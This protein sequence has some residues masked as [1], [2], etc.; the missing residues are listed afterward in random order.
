MQHEYLKPVE[1]CSEELEQA[2][3]NFRDNV[4]ESYTTHS[5]RWSIWSLV[6]DYLDEGIQ[7]CLQ[8][9]G[10]GGFFEGD[11]FSEF[12]KR[13]GKTETD[14]H[15][16]QRYKYFSK[17]VS[18]KDIDQLRYIAFFCYR[19]EP[20]H[21]SNYYRNKVK[22]S[23]LKEYDGADYC[24]LCWRLTRRN[25]RDR[26][27]DI[28]SSRFC[29]IHNPKDHNSL[30]RADHNQKENFRKN[31]RR[32]ERTGYYFNLHAHEQIEHSRKIAYRM[33]K[34]HIRD[35]DIEIM[36]MLLDGCSQPEIARKYKVSR[37]NISKFKKKI[38]GLLETWEE[39]KSSSYPIDPEDLKIW[40]T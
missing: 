38:G 24:E 7:L 39:L 1:G 17:G 35:S 22:T 2:L 18:S 20:Y 6:R 3:I 15:I 16:T 40:E 12:C 26:P 13:H 32:I 14:I 4:T 25:K 31:L 9:T 27:I 36:D 33:T 11:R 5:R 23:L 34:L 29:E 19:K 21:T 28:Q 8:K 10:D 30:Y 37:Q